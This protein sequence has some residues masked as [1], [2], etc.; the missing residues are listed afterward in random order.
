M[1]LSELKLL[2]K[3]LAV[4]MLIINSALLI[5]GNP[6]SG[7]D[8]FEFVA[9]L[10]V[11]IIPIILFSGPYIY[12]YQHVSKIQ[13]NKSEVI[14]SIIAVLVVSFTATCLIIAIKSQRDALSIGLALIVVPVIQIIIYKTIIA[15]FKMGSTH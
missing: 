13:D 11:N 8:L 4:I 3:T 12:A 7:T 10:F 9:M 15:L 6:T 2:S 1:E 5:K 14:S